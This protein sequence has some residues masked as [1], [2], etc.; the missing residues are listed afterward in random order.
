M[1]FRRQMDTISMDS[2]S[3]IFPSGPLYK[4]KQKIGCAKFFY[5]WITGLVYD[6]GDWWSFMCCQLSK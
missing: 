1:S 3:V 2:V 4:M 6:I 5:W